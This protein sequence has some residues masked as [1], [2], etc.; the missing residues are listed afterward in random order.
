M[1]GHVN[2]GK[3]SIVNAFLLCEDCSEHKWARLTRT[4]ASIKE[5]GGD[6]AAAANTLQDVHVE[7]FGLLS[8]QE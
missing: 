8:K 1:L 6:M 7:T 2:V 4:L 3:S 5:E